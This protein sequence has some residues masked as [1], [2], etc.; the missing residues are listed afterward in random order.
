VLGRLRPVVDTLGP[1]VIAFGGVGGET[2]RESVALEEQVG[3]A[4]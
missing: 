4:K 2:M 1:R 3:D